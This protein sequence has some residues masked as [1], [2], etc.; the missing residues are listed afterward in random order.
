MRLFKGVKN[1]F[2]ENYKLIIFFLIFYFVINFPVPYY[3][4]TS[5]GITDLSD[6][7][8]IDG[9]YEQKGSYNLSYVNQAEGNVLTY[10]LSFVLPEW[11]TVEIEN[12]QINENESVNDVLLRDRLSLTQ[13]NQSAVLLAYT[14]AGKKA[15]IKSTKFYVTA[16]YDFLESSEQIK[17]GDIL[18]K[19]EGISVDEFEDITEKVQNSKVNDY[20]T[21]ELE[22]NGDIYESKV[23][24]QNKDGANLMG[25]GFYRIYDLELDP[26]IKFTFKDSESGSS[27]GLMTTL[28]IYDSL[29]E[30][31]LTHGLKIAG[32]GTISSSGKVGEIGGVKYKLA[33]AVKGKASIFLVPKGENYEEAIKVKKDRNYDIE[34]VE[35]ETLD[36]A[37]S[38]LKNYKTTKE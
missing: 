24:V 35:I 28:A 11:E 29:I 30:E 38:F 19:V 22:R 34:I 12:Y 1:F 15:E 8:I 23:K 18:L 5:G 33:G 27:A 16:I 36:Q 20:L 13:A 32:T 4:F 7:F 14:R 17:I 6:R 21:L 25:L 3:V 37:I 9:S 10:L 2:R 26:E 31:D